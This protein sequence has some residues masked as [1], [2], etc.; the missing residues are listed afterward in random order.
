MPDA[1]NGRIEPAIFAGQSLTPFTGRR[2]E[3]DRLG[4][5][6][7]E[8]ELVCVHGPVG[9][10]KSRLCREAGRELSSRFP[11]GI[12][13]A[14]LEGVRTHPRLVS[15]VAQAAGLSFYSSGGKLE[16]LAAYLDGRRMLLVCDGI[17]DF[18][19]LDGLLD[20]LLPSLGRAVVL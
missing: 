15:A 4:S 19:G 16:Q 6:L 20:G 8:H 2:T 13:Y 9:I 7:L 11:D 10:G 17:E 1:E 12:G 14:A 5:L 18:D 3:L